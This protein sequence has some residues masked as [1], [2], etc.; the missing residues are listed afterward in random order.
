MAG[1]R[2]GSRLVEFSGQI[3]RSGLAL[4]PALTWAASSSVAAAWFWVI[5]VSLNSAGRFRACGTSPCTAAT[6]AL[7]VPDVSTGSAAPA[8]ATP[9]AQAKQAAGSTRRST[10]SQARHPPASAT[11]KVS[12]GGP[13]TDTQRAVGAAAWLM[14]SR[15]HGKPPHGHRSRR[16]SSATHQPATATGQA[17]SRSSSR[18]PTVST[19]KMRASLTASAAQA[20][21]ARFTTHDSSGTKNARPK[22]VPT[23]N[24]PRRLCPRSASTS[25]AGRLPEMIDLALRLG[26]GRLEV[27]HVQYYGWA[28]ANRRALLPTEAQLE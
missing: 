23:A 10:T 22:T 18:W 1:Y 4:R 6:V 7:A 12:S 2:N 28:L 8:S 25:N 3:T 15:P 21:Q 20:Y 27:A 5:W 11:R 17:R 26:A 9:A 14:T 13:P 16:A 19:A 24:E